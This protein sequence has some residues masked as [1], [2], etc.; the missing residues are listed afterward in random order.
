M[1][2]LPVLGTEQHKPPQAI[3]DLINTTAHRDRVRP[4]FLGA[5]DLK[6]RR[7]P[8]QPTFQGLAEAYERLVALTQVIA[9][10]FELRKLRFDPLNGH[11]T[12]SRIRLGLKKKRA[13]LLYRLLALP[14]LDGFLAPSVRQRCLRRDHTLLANLFSVQRG[15]IL[16]PPRRINQLGWNRPNTTHREVTRLDSSQPHATIEVADEVPGCRE[17]ARAL[18]PCALGGPC[19]GARLLRLSVATLR[20][21]RGGPDLQRPLSRHQAALCPKSLELPTQPENLRR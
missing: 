17:S 19:S 14:S 9:L 4:V 16:S 11:L 1:L 8:L 12:R 6:G 20:H 15:L 10:H 2:S 5:G 18:V 21:T 7:K 13:L 3:V